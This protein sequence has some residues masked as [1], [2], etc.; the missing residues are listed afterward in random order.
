MGREIHLWKGGIRFPKSFHLNIKSRSGQLPGTK[1]PVRIIS[2]GEKPDGNADLYAAL[3]KSDLQR[4]L[5]DFDSALI[6][7]FS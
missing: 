2:A 7:S 3:V 4:S 5:H 1:P 6:H